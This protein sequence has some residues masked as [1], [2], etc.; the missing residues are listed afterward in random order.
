MGI[1]Y[2]D[3]Q[4]GKYYKGTS[5]SAGLTKVFTFVERHAVL[6]PNVQVTIWE[7]Q[8]SPAGSWQQRVV[9]QPAGM[10]SGLRREVTPAEVQQEGFPLV[11]PSSIS[12]Q[13]SNPSTS[14][15]TSRLSEKGVAGQTL[16]ARPSKPLA[17]RKNGTPKAMVEGNAKSAVC[18]CCGQPN[19]T[20][21]LF[22]GSTFWC[23]ACEP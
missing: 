2:Q 8:R 12:A 10:D 20:L 17:L 11:A 1:A 14:T 3:L 19:K 4:A 9:M 16:S 7:V 15:P 21:V 22:R 13:G 6:P 5:G 18:L 23:P